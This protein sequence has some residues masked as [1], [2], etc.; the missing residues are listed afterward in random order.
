M[1]KLELFDE[2]FDPDR[3]ESYELSIQVSL[4]GFSFCVKDI[5]RNCFIGLGSCPFEVSSIS[6]DNWTKQVNFIT[7]SY[8]WLTKPFR[9]VLLTYESQ[10]FTLVP[11]DLFDQDRAKDILSLAHPINDLDEVRFNQCANNIV[12]VFNIPTLLVTEW[13]KIHSKTKFIGYCAPTL[14]LHQLSTN[15][16]KEAT[17]TLSFANKFAILI[18][19]ANSK[20]LHCGSIDLHSIDDTI[21]HMVNSCKQLGVNPN[22]TLVKLMGSY[23]QNENLESLIERFFKGVSIAT[24]LDQNHFSY[25]LNKY[26]GKFANLFNQSLCE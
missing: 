3:T 24:T 4:N 22:E 1:Q 10:S 5:T 12:A 6:S 19:S 26:K 23:N 15:G 14:Q 2:T 21:Y 17:I 7:K 20:L 9:K 16:T 18:I 11:K 13:L 25:L 8:S